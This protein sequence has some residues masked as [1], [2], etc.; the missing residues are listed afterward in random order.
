MREHTALMEHRMPDQIAFASSALLSFI[1]FLVHV[2]VGGRQVARPLLDCDLDPMVLQTQY[3]CW[4]LTSVTIAI[5]ALF[6]AMAVWLDTAAYG[7]AGLILAAGFVLV[8]IGMVPLRGWSYK[9]VPQGWLFVP[10]VALAAFGVW[11]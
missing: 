9:I 3:L 7:V 8:G 5:M 6:F 11:G 10:V 1:W 4:H 2:F